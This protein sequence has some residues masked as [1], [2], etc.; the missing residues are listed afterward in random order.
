[1]STNLGWLGTGRMGA[2]LAGRLIDAGEDVTVWNRTAAKAEPLVAR[3]ARA[4]GRITDLGGCDIVFVTVSGPRDLE[5]VVYGEYGLLSGESKPGMVVDCST[6][7]DS[8]SASVRAAAQAA[9]VGFLAAPVSGNPHV[10][11]AG[12]ACIV[13]SGPAESFRLAKP[14]LDA[15]AKVAVYAGEAEQ[16]RL[17][18]LCHNLYL[19]MMVQALVEVTT[20]AEKGGT[21]RAAFLEFLGGTVVASEWVRRRTG[22]LVARDWTPTFTT[23]LLRKDFDLGL[24]AARSLEVPMPVAASVHQLIQSAIGL[25]LRNVDFLSLYDQQALGAGLARDPDSER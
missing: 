15:M 19:G 14:Y 16:S 13:A 12:G 2:A 18:K 3:G 21:D 10:V 22:D 25:G 4:A 24:E 11:A 8:A 9:G 17:V 5:E 1:M 23:E 6:V 7:S 20:L